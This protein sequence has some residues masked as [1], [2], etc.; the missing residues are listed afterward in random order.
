MLFRSEITLYCKQNNLEIVQIFTEKISG[1]KE[2]KERE[3]LTKLMNFVTEE[4]NEISGI[5]ITEI[6]RLGRK[7]HD[8]LTNINTLNDCGVYVNALSNHKKTL[9][10]DKSINRE[11]NLLLGIMSSIAE[12]ERNTIL[13]RSRSGLL[14][15]AL[16]GN[17]FGGINVPYGYTKKDKKLEIDIEESDVVRRIFN[18]YNNGISIKN[19]AKELNSL[20][21]QTRYNK[22]GRTVNINGIERTSNSFNWVPNTLYRILKNPLYKGKKIYLEKDSKNKVIKEHII[23]QP[24]IV[25]EKLFDSVQLKLSSNYSKQGINRKFEYVINANQYL[26]N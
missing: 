8:V 24:I 9:N 25:D 1:S 15:S 17:F 18:S 13:T 5:I 10:D 16:N 19:I 21:V 14:N 23:K 22:L 3:E 2:T 11:S 7:I 6:S 4:T 12:A 26:K 20:P